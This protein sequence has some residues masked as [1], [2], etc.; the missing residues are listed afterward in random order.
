MP[1]QRS[2]G[3]EVLLTARRTA[4]R[5]VQLSVISKLIPK[6]EMSVPTGVVNMEKVTA[7]ELTLRGRQNSSS[8]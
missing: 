7:Q 5:C 1:L 4:N 2:T 8:Q 3:G 6:D